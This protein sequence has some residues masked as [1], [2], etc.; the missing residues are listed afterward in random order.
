MEVYNRIF[1]GNI[2]SLVGKVDAICITTNG[3]IKKD[4]SNVMGKGVAKQA[5]DKWPGLEFAL[6]RLIKDNGNHVQKII[7][8]EGTYI[9]SFPTKPDHI[10]IMNAS[11]LNQKVVSYMR[12]KMS[13]TNFCPGWACKSDINLIKQ[14][15]SELIELADKE[16]WKSVAIPKPGCSNGEL[17]WKEVS[18]IL[19]DILDDRFIICDIGGKVNAGKK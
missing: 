8:I 10:Y 12:S 6:G 13:I 5:R 2:F 19:S 17:N 1:N 7:N 4:G 16:G 15:A 9:V 18:G 14:S 3:C 11:D